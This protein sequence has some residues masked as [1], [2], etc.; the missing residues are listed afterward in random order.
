MDNRLSSDLQ[1]RMQDEK[2][3]L[4]DGGIPDGDHHR[5]EY[6]LLRKGH[7]SDWEYSMEM[8]WINYPE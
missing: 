7:L 5:P 2:Q 1:R 6:R 8:S 4:V 3:S